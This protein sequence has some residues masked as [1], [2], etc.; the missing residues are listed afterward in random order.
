MIDQTVEFDLP[1]PWQGKRFRRNRIG[2]INYL[3]GPNGSGKSR[4]A[5]TLKDA[6]PNARLLGTD[7]IQGTGGILA[8]AY[9]RII[10]IQDI[11]KSFFSS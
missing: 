4:F 2:F 10:L 8:L 3:V 6:L 1:K 11:K 5:A 9:G 7:R